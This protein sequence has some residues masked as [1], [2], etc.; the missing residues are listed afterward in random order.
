MQQAAKKSI[1]NSKQSKFPRQKKVQAGKKVHKHTKN[2]S[3]GQ[4]YFKLFFG[5][6]V[7]G[8]FG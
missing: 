4:A 2:N 7:K 6:S 3:A 1:S 8:G 5:K